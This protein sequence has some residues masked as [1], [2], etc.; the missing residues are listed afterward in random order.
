MPQPVPL[1][2]IMLDKPRNL[3]F[4]YNAICDYETVS[5]ERFTNLSKNELTCSQLRVLLW[6]SLRHEDPTLT[7]EMVG[8]MM[9]FSGL[10]EIA[11]DVTKAI[12]AALPDQKEGETENPKA[13]PSIG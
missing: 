12:A 4:G 10:S 3:R 2:P 13:G 11:K 1:I 7:L 8:D 5:G 9:G 6:A